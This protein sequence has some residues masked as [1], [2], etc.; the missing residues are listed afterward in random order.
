MFMLTFIDSAMYC[1]CLTCHSLTLLCT[2]YVYVVIQLTQF[3]TAH[4][5]VVGVIHWLCYVLSM[6]KLTFIEP[7]MNCPCLC[8]HTLSLLCIVICPYLSCHTL[9]LLCTTHSYVDIQLTLQVLSIFMLSFNWF[10]YVLSMSMLSF[11]DPTTALSMFMLSFIDSAMYCLCLCCRSLTLQCT[12]YVYV[13]I[14]LTLLC[15][16]Q[17]YVVIQLTLLWTVHVYVVIH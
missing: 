4:V 13:V 1:P 14:Q 7:A 15:T 2:V 16:V 3:C 6:F 10:C 11:T 17:V 5:C 12:V 8:C 9:T